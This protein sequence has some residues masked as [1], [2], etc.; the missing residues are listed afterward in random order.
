MRRAAFFGQKRIIALLI[1]ALM[2]ASAFTGC[3]KDTNDPKASQ[4]SATSASAAESIS[5]ASE[6]QSESGEKTSLKLL[7]NRERKENGLITEVEALSFDGKCIKTDSEFRITASKD[8]S[9]EEIRSRISISPVTEFSVAKE[10]SNTYLLTGSKPLPEGCL[11]KLAA[12]DEKGD[13]RDSWA[14]QTTEKFK[15]KSVYPADGKEY[16]SIDSG[17]EIEFSSP[18]DI[19]SAKEH[20]EITP[21]PNGSYEFESH[22]NTLYYIPTSDR[23][24]SSS[25]M[26][27]DTVYTVTLKK[28][29][30]SALSGELEKDFSFEFKTS[31]G[32]AAYFYVYNSAGNFSETFIEGD[33]MVIEIYCSGGLK[34]KNFDLDLY[35]YASSE[36]YRRDF[37]KFTEDKRRFPE[38]SADVSGLE[39]VFSS[40][41]PPIPNTSEWRPSFIMLPDDLEEGYY[42]ADISVIGLHEQYMIQVNPISV[43]AL[44][45]GE[46]NAFFIND[47]KTGKAAE[48]AKVN[49]TINGNTYTA[50][51]DKDG[52]ASIKTGL[53]EGSKGILTV[54]YG[55]SSYIDLF[56]SYDES[57]SSYDDKYFMYLYTDRE[58]YLTSDTVNVWGIILPRRDGVTL[59][60]KLSLRIG[61]SDES[62]VVNEVDIAPDGTFKSSF[63][64]T[65]HKE[66]WYTNIYLLDGGNEMCQKWISIRDYVKPT[67]TV[68]TTL[69]DYAVMPQR[70]PV[71]IEVSAQFYEG[72]PAAG[73]NFET[74]PNK[75]TIT[76]DENGHAKAEL[77]FDDKDEWRMYNEYVSI[78]LTGVEN[79]YDYFYDYVPSFYRDVM[80]ETDY[81][82]QTHSLTL[83]T[84][85]L[86]F[87]KIE[88]FLAQC[89]G[90]FYRDNSS[91]DILKGKLFDTEVTVEIKHSYFKKKKAGTYYDFIEKKTVDRYEYDYVTDDIGTFTAKTVG[92]K[93]VL[94]NLPTDSLEGSYSFYI[95][96]KD[97]LGQ[98]TKENV[99]YYNREYDYNYSSPFKHYYLRSEKENSAGDPYYYEYGYSG[100][101][102]SYVSFKENETLSFEL[103]CNKEDFYTSGGRIFLA[104]Y[105]DDFISQNVYSSQKLKY[106]PSLECLPN[107]SFEGAYFDG[108]HVYPVAGG[109]MKF[110]P[111]E[112]NIKLEASSDRDVYDAGDTVRLT[113]KATDEKG[114]PVANAPVMLSVADE[115][116]FALYSQDVDILSDVYSYIYYPAA[117]NYYS[118]IEHV[119]GEDNMG[120]KGGGGDEGNVRDYFNDNPYFGAVVT[121]SNGIAEFEFKLADNLTTWRATLI[122]AKS[123]ETGRLIAGNTTYP[124]VA[125]RPVFITPIMLDTFIEG[126]DIAVTAKC[127][128]IGADD[129]ITVRLTG[130]GVDKTLNIKS[131]ETANFGKLAKGE[132][133][134]LFTAE[135]DGN[136]DAVELPLTVTDTILETDIHRES[137]LADGIAINPT[138]WPV[139]LTFFDKE[140]MFYTDILRDLAFYYGE[141]TDM[142]MADGFARK[143]LGYITEEEYI[144]QYKTEDS[145]ISILENSDESA[146]Y[147]AMLCAALPELAN[148]SGAKAKFEK[149]LSDLDAD[150]EDICI[151]Y[152]GLAALGEP[153]MEEVKAALESGEFTDYYDGMRLTAA[154]A[155]CGDYDTAYE[156]FVK[157]TPMIAVYDSDP[158]NISAAVIDDRE[159]WQTGTYEF[160]Q[161]SET[162]EYT[163]LA[164]VTASLLKLPE[165]DYFARYLYSSWWKGYDSDA[166]EFALYLKNY[167]PDVEGDAVFTYNLNGKTETVK[168]DRYHGKRL[169]FGEE[170]FKNAD[171]KLTSGSVLVMSSYIGRV[172]E[173]EDPAKMSITKTLTGDFTVGGEV[174]VKI[175]ADK[176][177][178]VDDV[179][180]SCGRYTGYAWGRSGQRIFLFTDIMGNAEYKFRIVSEGEFVVESAV[181]QS[182]NSWGE[183]KRDTIT[184]GKKDEKE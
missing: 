81:D 32:D 122:A 120:E 105:Q 60:K 93:A 132:Y 177:C 68:E 137:E 126:D 7:E 17:I 66:T 95:T 89:S 163:R 131:A 85:Q 54:E 164:M 61:D 110:D 57:E 158:G 87:S 96:Y 142:K 169:K 50:K 111:E 127:S 99:Y 5:A 130:E 34:E 167:V 182:R 117:H 98:E 90:Y 179:I 135:K 63:S 77:I 73:L 104:V 166:M 172:S 115:A 168:L 109:S 70:D 15:I 184:V 31:R 20:F 28:G 16:V 147:T 170:Q 72:T 45:L 4:T 18:V 156:Y 171:F 64:F 136:R 58:C 75:K 84:T 116:A 19:E 125:K 82:K 114:R 152:M 121:D 107:A 79:E 100:Y 112:R 128:G 123:L 3:K 59:P 154:L 25:R 159:S 148:R 124:I 160:E 181:V 180:P 129:E 1:S 6:K 2:L 52:V 24:L 144:E 30:K 140:Y 155:L 176:W 43:Y 141:R 178:S 78:G 14:F 49:L 36:D 149:M 13:I 39:K 113:V 146:K 76:T 88:E 150:K 153:V 118:Y 44:S 56:S 35:R 165:A 106:S 173:Q 29:L 53:K 41:G 157:L 22:R 26:R 97:S 139:T 119:I 74:R 134:A 65:D 55:S 23:Y 143:E 94:K 46:E 12:A 83:K 92:G 47:T 10:K 108:R 62:G 37:E 48:G 27:Q 71:P 145:F 86:D 151:A 161:Y 33:P 162:R 51:S 80:L 91:Y 101:Y 8:V 42:I 183:S 102:Y 67:Y 69:P 103:A 21:A 174:T 38:F 138:K 9:P 133:K 11:V 175:K 40:S